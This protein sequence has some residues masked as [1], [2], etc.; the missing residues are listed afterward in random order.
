E[1]SKKRSPAAKLT[2]GE[3]ALLEALQKLVPV[4]YDM[5]TFQSVLDDLSKKL[6]G[7]TILI[8]KQALEEANVTYD[9]PITLHSNKPVTARPALKR[10]LADV[11]LTYVIRKE[12]IEVTTVARAREMLTTRTY[13]LGDLVG[14]GNPLLPA[15][16]NQFQM[17]QAIGT[18][19][20]QIQGID[21]D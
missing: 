15:V 16:A 9:T 3:K 11:G 13:Y 14:V 4:D 10:V 17:M 19:I 1:K 5:A 21:P 2:A 7:Q 8:D 12:T 20:N 6:G 18:I